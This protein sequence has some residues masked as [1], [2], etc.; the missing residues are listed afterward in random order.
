MVELGEINDARLWQ[1]ALAN[2]VPLFRT[3]EDNPLVA[4][5]DDKG[6]FLSEEAKK[7]YQEIIPRWHIYAARSGASNDAIY[8][9]KT[10]QTGGRWQ[11]SPDHHLGG[12]A[13]VILGTASKSSKYRRHW[14]KPWFEIENFERKKHAHDSMYHIKM[15]QNVIISFYVPELPVTKSELRAAEVR[16]VRLAKSKGLNVLNKRVDC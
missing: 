8:I 15:K 14:V 2:P 11:R 7:V 4:L 13:H 10:T 5:F 3:A 1:L 9:G 12:L 16:L 6:F